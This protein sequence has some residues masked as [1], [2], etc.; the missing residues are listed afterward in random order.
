MDKLEDPYRICDWCG[1]QTRGLLREDTNTI[2]CGR[3]NLPL[4]KATPHELEKIHQE[5]LPSASVQTL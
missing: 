4:D 2:N 3:C 5:R 1:T